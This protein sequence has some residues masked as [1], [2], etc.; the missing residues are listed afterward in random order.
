MAKNLVIVESPAKSRTIEKFLGSGYKVLASFGHVRDLP[1]SKIG[2]DIK[3][4]FEP[5]YVIPQKAKKVIIA[6]K[7]EIK[8][9]DKVYLATDYDREGEAIAWHIVQAAGLESGKK[10]ELNPK[11]KRIT[12]HEITKPAIEEAITHPRDLDLHLVDAQQARRVLDRLV[13]YKLS[14]FLWRKVAQGLSAGRVQSVALRM[15]VEREREIEKFKPDEY[16]T[17]EAMLTP[18]TK[19]NDFK[20]ILASMD[21]KKIEK[22]AISN[23]KAAQE[24]LTKLE[25]AKYIVDEVSR[26]ERRRYPAPPF[27]TSTLQ[28][29]AAKKLGF[30]AKQ[31][32]MIAQKLYEEGH[33]TYM[34]TDSVQVSTLAL[35][36]SVKVIDEKFGKKYSLP[37]PRIFKTK[38]RGAQEAHEA[39]R[40]THLENYPDDIKVKD[41]EAKLY[42]LIWKRMLA[43]QM[44]E[45]IMDEMGVKIKASNFGFSA[46]GSQIK[47][48]GFLKVYDETDEDE[49]KE[50]TKLLPE[51]KVGQ[52]LTLEEIN[53][54]QHFTEPPA[55]F[56]EGNLVK[57]LEKLGI[58]RP[59]TYAPTI[60]TIQERGYVDKVS[61]RFIPKE[62][63][64]AVND[65]L[66]EHFPDIVDYNFT[67]KMEEE[68]DDVAEGKLEWQPVIKEFYEPFAKNLAEK[69]E[70]V[71]KSE[72]T[73]KTDEKCPECG[74]EM[75]IK[76][77]RFGKFMAC[78]GFPDCKFTKPLLEKE[79]GGKAAEEV[80]EEV[81][82]EKCPKCG[83]SLLLK[84]AR[85]GPFLACEG[86]PKCKFTKSIEIKA[87]VPCPN[88][89]GDLARKS[90]R[91]GRAFWGCSNYPKC[92]TAFWQE[93]IKEKC[94]QCQSLMM[95][96]SRT[97]LVKCSKC[98]YKEEEK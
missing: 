65:I 7:E 91:K 32:M 47:F 98:D 74:K 58:G 2:V 72:F 83:S 67:A 52:E 17:I 79:I 8:K 33:I 66:V 93:P 35:N 26:E 59:S 6:L 27:T 50:V 81:E 19:E 64:V 96:D 51:L 46:S 23:D 4:N 37:A 53:K 94:P 80:Q 14:P 55:R 71:Q 44:T 43:S 39:I 21:G 22:L 18:D 36:A 75:V 1:S 48:D 88:C 70:S 3:K 92:K 56:S 9:A 45:A 15:I 49:I 89:G 68:L 62:I 13:G 24:I 16:W 25:N 42:D 76:M 77:G 5:D 40:P 84:E 82:K 95:R 54:I 20:A 57:E 90:T 11:V 69:M 60:S 63:G 85:F 41:T 30:S 31:T 86:Y 12:F 34:R 38:T 87:E 29:E 78:T 73:E 97:K 61:G 10:H 28:Q